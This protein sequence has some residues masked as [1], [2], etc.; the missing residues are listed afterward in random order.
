MDNVWRYLRFVKPYW[1]KIIIT[2]VVG[3]IKFGIPMTV[4]LVLKY[5]FDDII[6]NEVLTEQQKFGELLEIMGIM[7]FLFL[8]VRPPIE[9]FRQYYAQWIG[10]K[11]L[12]DIRK[13]LFLHI[14]RLSLRYYANA[15]TGEII[16]RVINDVEQ[17]KNFVITGLMNIW[18]DMATI[19][20]A[21]LIMFQMNAYLTLAAVILLPV[22]MFCVKYFYARLRALTRNRSQSLGF[23]Q[24]FLTERIQGISVTKSFSRHDFE[25]E[26]FEKKNQHFWQS[27]LQ[28]TKWNA[29]TFAI[30]NTVTDIAPLIVILFSGWLAIEGNLT[31]GSMVAFIGYLDRLYD[32]LRRLVNSSTTLTQSLASMDRV[33]DFLD[34]SYDIT[35]EEHPYLLDN[36]RGEI[37]FQ[38]VGFSYAPGGNEI[39]NQLNLHIAPGKNVALV[40]SSGG[41]KSTVVTLIPRFYDVTS[42]QI[43]VD[44]VDVRSIELHSLRS[45]IGMVLQDTF[46]FSDSIGENIRYGNPEAL[47][48]EVIAA[49]KK[50]QIH[51]FICSL[52]EG[53]ET[54][55]GE[56]GI[57]LSGGQKQRV[58]IA[59]LFLKNPSILILDEATS[60]LDLENEQHIQK[61]L[62]ELAKG[63]TTITIAHRLST[64]THVDTIYYIDNGSVIEEGTHQ[65]LLQ[66][67]GAYA[68]LYSMQNLEK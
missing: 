29:Q 31:L 28:H 38:N 19:V 30:V 60:A 34:E 67:K 57:K 23:M 58:A 13:Q 49:A 61:A 21:L 14:Q 42:G 32:P 27:S 66:K 6:A 46:L 63:R 17:T 12:Y 15:K 36:V 24:G 48:S 43:C 26:N 52:P 2:I 41:G 18:L 10:S 40:G 62:I 22:Y 50:A 16:N 25:V 7:A 8:I 9:Y 45:A 64:I 4:P 59:R 33:F 3:L 44:G 47:E 51:D 56:R 11:I 68:K 5:I 35:N 54:L 1:G 37:A 39:L 55:V 65:E 20:I 53:Y